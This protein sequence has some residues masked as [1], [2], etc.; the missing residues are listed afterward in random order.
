MMSLQDFR[1]PGREGITIQAEGMTGNH[2][3]TGVTQSAYF[4]YFDA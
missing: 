2:I 4:S 1:A 3:Q